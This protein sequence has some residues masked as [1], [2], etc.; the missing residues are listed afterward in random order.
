MGGLSRRRRRRLG[1]RILS[2]DQRTVLLAV[3]V[4]A[5]VAFH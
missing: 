4:V 2:R 5:V 1:G 3:D